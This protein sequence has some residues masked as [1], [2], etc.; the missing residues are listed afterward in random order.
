[1]EHAVEIHVPSY[2]PR[3]TLALTLHSFTVE[4]GKDRAYRGATRRAFFV[5]GLDVSDESVLREAAREAGLD[6]D[7][8]MEAVWDPARNLGLGSVREEALRLGV[9]GVPMVTTGTDVLYYGAAEPGHLRAM[10][11]GGKD[12]GQV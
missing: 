3:S 10:L 4:E 7:A 5:D 8:A 12:A 11:A 9:R 1:M 2:Q 6:A